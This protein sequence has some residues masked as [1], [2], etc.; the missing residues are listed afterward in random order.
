MKYLSFSNGMN[1]GNKTT[2]SMKELKKQRAI[3]QYHEK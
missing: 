1:K 3:V 2:K